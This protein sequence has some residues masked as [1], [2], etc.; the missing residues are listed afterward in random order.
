VRTRDVA[1]HIRL[2][3]ARCTWTCTPEHF[4]IQKRLLP[5]APGNGKLVADLLNV[6][7]LQAHDASSHLKKMSI[8]RAIF[9][10]QIYTDETRKKLWLQDS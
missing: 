9:Q 5:V 3:T 7:W 8:L 6:C 10:P 2:A 1:E 4:K